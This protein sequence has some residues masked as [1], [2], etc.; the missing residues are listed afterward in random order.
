YFIRL[1]TLIGTDF[2]E[3]LPVLGYLAK[4]IGVRTWRDTWNEGVA[5]VSAE[6]VLDTE[7]AWEVGGFRFSIGDPSG[8]QAV[9]RLEIASDRN[10][11]LTAIADRAEEMEGVTNPVPRDSLQILARADGPV[12]VSRIQLHDLDLRVRLPKD[13]AKK[14]IIVGTNRIEPDGDQP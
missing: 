5:V 1:A 6:A 8:G 7:I 13:W 14:G 3:K 2:P 12:P 11:I 9:F 10:S 4:N